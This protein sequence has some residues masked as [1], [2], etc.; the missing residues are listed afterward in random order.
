MLKTPLNSV[1]GQKA[2][3]MS[4]S[5]P[6]RWNVSVSVSVTLVL[7]HLQ[8]VLYISASALTAQ[9]ELTCGLRPSD[10]NTYQIIW[11]P[12]HRAQTNTGNTRCDKRQPWQLAGH[13][14][15]LIPTGPRSSVWG[16]RKSQPVEM[17]LKETLWISCI[18]FGRG[19][20]VMSGIRSQLS[21]MGEVFT[22]CWFSSLIQ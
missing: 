2:C 6:G 13:V 5:D 22:K 14:F 4:V 1:K 12:S 8:H 19:F 3:V 16:S 10:T 7:P 11:S 18:C 15:F 17:R 20:C 21:N 9:L